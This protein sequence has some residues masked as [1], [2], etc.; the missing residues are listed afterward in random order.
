MSE[1]VY[2]GQESLKEITICELSYED[3]SVII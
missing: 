1:Q 3:D 2:N